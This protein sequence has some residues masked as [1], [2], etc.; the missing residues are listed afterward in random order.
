MPHTPWFSG[1]H[2]LRVVL[3][4]TPPTP[5]SPSRCWSSLRTLHALENLLSRQLRGGVVGEGVHQRRDGRK[6][7]RLFLVPDTR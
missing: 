4:Q 6:E 2:H 3:R 7:A 1:Q 5:T